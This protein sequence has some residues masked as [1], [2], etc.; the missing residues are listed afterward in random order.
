VIEIECPPTLSQGAAGRRKFKGQFKLNRRLFMVTKRGKPDMRMR[1]DYEEVS[2]TC[3]LKDF[4]GVP[5]DH[6]DDDDDAI[7]L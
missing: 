3:Q 1:L 2:Q 5:A 6:D 4:A 7:G